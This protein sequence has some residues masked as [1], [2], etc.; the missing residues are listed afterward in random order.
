MEKNSLICS[1]TVFGGWAG[2]GA[3]VC[4]AVGVG[5]GTLVGDGSRVGVAGCVGTGVGEEG[6]AM[7]VWMI[8]G[9]TQ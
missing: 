2:A 3:G 6:I 5:D 7:S 4:V 8:R 9:A 1:H